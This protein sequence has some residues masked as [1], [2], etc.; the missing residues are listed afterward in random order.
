MIHRFLEKKR[1]RS[2]FA[3]SLG[4]GP[5]WL[6]FSMLLF[7]FYTEN[8]RNVFHYLNIFGRCFFFSVFGFLGVV[9]EMA[10]TPLVASCS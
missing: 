10:I 1:E 3:C 7:F 5:G 2:L 6:S 9:L 4:A 8:E